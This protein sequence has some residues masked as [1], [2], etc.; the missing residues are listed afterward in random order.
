MGS[1]IGEGETSAGAGSD[2]EVESGYVI[3]SEIGEGEMIAGSDEAM[4]S[5]IEEL[6]TWQ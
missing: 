5:E 3:E 6:Y 1:E 2:A 4:G